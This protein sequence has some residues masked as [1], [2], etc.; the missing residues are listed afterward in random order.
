M[1]TTFQFTVVT[2]RDEGGRYVA[3]C[4]A[5]PGCYTEGTT[6]AEADALIEDAVRLHIEERIER[7]EHIGQEVAVSK[8]RVAV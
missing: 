2:E 3:I 6:Q 1:A 7:G 4:P 8:V 5:L